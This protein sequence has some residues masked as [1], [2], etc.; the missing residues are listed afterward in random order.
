M[1]LEKLLTVITIVGMIAGGAIGYGGL[2][3]EAND[4][5]K[6]LEII[7]KKVQELEV[8]HGE[9]KIRIEWMIN[10]LDDLPAPPPRNYYNQNMKK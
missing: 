2:M 3:K 6:T 4:S 1:N 10:E 8:E 9:T 5:A 7:E